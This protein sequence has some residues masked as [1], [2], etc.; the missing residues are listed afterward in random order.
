MSSRETRATGRASRRQILDAA[1]EIAGERGYSGTSISAVSKR[2]GLPHSSIYWHFENKD[3]LFAA[4]IE[5]SYTRWR[6]QLEQHEPGAAGPK[7][8]LE[9]LYAGLLSFPHFV[10]LGLMITLEQAPDGERP[11]RRRFREIRQESLAELRVALG[12]GYPGLTKRQVA[13]LAATTLAL[14][15]GAFLAAQAGETDLSPAQLSRTVDAYAKAMQTE[16]RPNTRTSPPA[17]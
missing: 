4:V 16:A 9:H 5:D 14:L 15:D 6:A 13:A 11:A 8:G 10:R 12:L 3:D 7:E 1:A 2:S 17:S